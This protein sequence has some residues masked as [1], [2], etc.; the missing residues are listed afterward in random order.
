MPPVCPQADLHHGQMIREPNDVALE[1]S[2]NPTASGAPEP[3]H[4]PGAAR[5]AA[6]LAK[7]VDRALASVD[8]SLAQYR[9]LGF[10]D[11]TASAPAGSLAEA[12]AVSRPSITGLIDG[13][14][15]RGLVERTADETDRRCVR[16]TLTRSGRRLLAA[17]DDAVDDAFDRM[18]APL[19]EA[20]RRAALQ[21]LATWQRAIDLAMQRHAATA[22]AQS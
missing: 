6:R 10:L 4:T 9:V 15:A 8:L 7:V 18:L 21:G 19:A 20:D 16:H 1:R 2:V 22:T 13:L 17:A 3:R 5:G 11:D 12:L 14:V